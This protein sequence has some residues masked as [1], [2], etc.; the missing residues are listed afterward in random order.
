M[1]S[2]K[3]RGF[4]LLAAFAMVVS[5]CGGA[6][7]SG[8]PAGSAAPGESAPAPSAGGGTGDFTFVVDSEPTTLAGIP[9]DLPTTWITNILYTS[10]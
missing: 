2:T 6:T 8:S 5:A 4:A 3:R 10:L 9:D 7:P 1:I